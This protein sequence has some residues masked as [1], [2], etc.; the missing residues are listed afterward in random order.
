MRYVVIPVLVLTVIL[1]GGT[2]AAAPVTPTPS[3]L[4]ISNV[5]LT[6]G[7]HSATLHWTTSLPAGGAVFYGP[8]DGAW[9]ESVPSSGDGLSHTATLPDLAPATAYRFWITA[10][11]A[12]GANAFTPPAPFTTAAAPATPAPADPGAPAALVTPASGALVSDDFNRTGGLG[13]WIFVN[14][15]GDAAYALTGTDMRL[16]VPDGPPHEPW[17]SGNA[18]VRLLQPTADVNFDVIAKFNSRVSGHI[19]LQGLIAQASDADYVRFDISSART[20]AGVEQVRLFAGRVNGGSATTFAFSTLAN[21]GHPTWL[22]LTRSGTSWTFRYSFDGETWTTFHTRTG[23]GMSVSS[24]GVFAGN[25]EQSG[26]YA[27]PFTA[28]VDYFH[29]AEAPLADDPVAHGD[30]PAPLLACPPATLNGTTLVVTGFSDAPTTAEMR[31][32]SRSAAGGR[33]TGA[34]GQTHRLEVSGLQRATTY[35]YRL[36]VTDDGGRTATCSGVV[37]VRPAAAGSAPVIDVWGGAQQTVGALGV[38]QRWVN[39]LGEVS[40]ADGFELDIET[41][42][43]GAWPLRYRLNGGAARSLMMGPGAYGNPWLNW[44]RVYNEG[45]FNIELGW[46]ELQEGVNTLE[47]TAVDRLGNTSVQTVTVTYEGG[48]RWS[49]PYTARWETAERV[50]DAAQ[51]VDGLW[52]LEEGSVRPVRTGYDRLLAIGDVTWTD[53]EVTA[54]ITIHEIDMYRGL[55]PNSGGPGV[56]LLVR[57]QGHWDAA[58]DLATQPRW[59]YYPLGALGWY[60]LERYPDSTSTQRVFHLHLDT[61]AATVFARDRSGLRLAVGQTYLFKMRVEGG[62][63]YRLKVW[64]AGSAEPAEWTVEGEA[65]G[66]AQPLAAGSVLL[67][68]HHVDASFGNVTIHPVG[69]SGGATATPSPSAT[70]TPTMTPGATATPSPS[71]TSTPTTTPGATATPSPTVIPGA[72]ATPG[73]AATPTPFAGTVLH[74]LWLPIIIQP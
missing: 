8:A 29:V 24:V 1:T 11:R 6:V 59:V 2:F 55:R 39:V 26:R 53:Y 64:E 73:D 48:R 69:G 35:W 19:A 14:P 31:Y 49:L 65:P 45:E 36:T 70:S 18:A 62:A 27:Q 51:A 47:I 40:D 3:S 74:R 72:T 44:R 20:A 52:G 7:A 28:A 71:A 57:W 37:R 68:A 46:E 21:P 42:G 50:E 33:V 12:D 25:A 67:V 34:R 58:G 30:G 10:Y 41:F 43:T 60:R 66:S 17:T 13:P 22:R 23:V 56:G 61:G 15:R 4:T 63:H 38:P 16:I 9:S 5:R 32:G 54:P